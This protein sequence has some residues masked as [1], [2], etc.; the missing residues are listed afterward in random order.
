MIIKR[1]AETRTDVIWP[2]LTEVVEAGG[3]SNP[4][5]LEMCTWKLGKSLDLYNWSVGF[6]VE[7]EDEY[8]EIERVW[9]KITLLCFGITLLREKIWTLLPD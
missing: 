8:Y 9:I 3:L 6:R 4:N 5:T 7:I 1:S 2:A